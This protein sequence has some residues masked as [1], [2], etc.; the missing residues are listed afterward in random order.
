VA[1][2]ATTGYR[3][4][5]PVPL[6]KNR[7]A[8]RWPFSC[9]AAA[10][11][12]LLALAPPSAAAGVE[13]CDRNYDGRITIAD[14]L[15]TLQSVISP[16]LKELWCDAD[17]DFEESVTDALA[18]LQY[19]IA[20]PVALECACIWID[21]CFEDSDCTGPGYPPGLFCLPYRCVECEF[22]TD[23]AAGLR[24]DR[25]TYTCTDAVYS[26]SPAPQPR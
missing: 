18:I 14:A 26:R 12:A 22:D 15:I 25:C 9:C 11:A 10:L 4:R 2:C 19:A 24:C 8:G 1:P 7:T 13:Q 23:C 16:C 17:G 6:R 3:M 20:L 21:E 5:M